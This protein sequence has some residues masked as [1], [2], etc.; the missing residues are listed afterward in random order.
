MY[1]VLVFLLQY[2]DC[3]TDLQRDPQIGKRTLDHGWGAGETTIGRPTG[4]KTRVSTFNTSWE[5]IIYRRT[6][7]FSWPEGARLSSLCFATPLLS[8]NRKVHF[9]KGALNQSDP[10]IIDN[11]NVT[12]NVLRTHFFPSLFS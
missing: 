8:S 7:R 5:S 1:L 3:T 6:M 4:Q 11:E 12:L 2:I 9:Q 10:K